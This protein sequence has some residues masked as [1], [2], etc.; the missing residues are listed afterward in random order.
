M[1]AFMDVLKRTD[2]NAAHEIKKE[3]LS[4]RERMSV[5]LDKLQT[6][7]ILPFHHCFTYEEGRMGVVVTFLAML[8]LLKS[9]IIEIVQSQPFAPIYIKGCQ[10]E[11]FIR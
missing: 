9:S 5:I 1:L 8:E 4:V 10:N 11:Q 6:T 2:L 7:S 3:L